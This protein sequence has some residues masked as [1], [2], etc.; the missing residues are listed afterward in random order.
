MLRLHV[1]LIL[2]FFIVLD[3][4]FSLQVLAKALF[5]AVDQNRN[6]HLDFTDLM[7]LITLL[8]KVAAQYGV[9]AP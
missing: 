1:C 4:F 7:A 9:A 8:N 6:G 3:R 2:I 5:Q